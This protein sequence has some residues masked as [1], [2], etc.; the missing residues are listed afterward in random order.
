MDW[1]GSLAGMFDKMQ[2]EK[3]SKISLKLARKFV[4]TFFLSIFFLT[5]L[6]F[7]NS[8]SLFFYSWIEK[9]AAKYEART[10]RI[11][12]IH[13]TVYGNCRIVNMEEA[14]KNKD[15][16]CI[17]MGELIHNRKKYYHL[18]LT[19][20][21]NKP[22]KTVFFVD[23]TKKSMEDVKRDI[24]FPRLVIK[25]KDNCVP[26]VLWSIIEGLPFRDRIVYL[27]F[28]SYIRTFCETKTGL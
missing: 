22:Y 2:S 23:K 13:K 15:K 21:C 27:K 19:S 28:I 6:L 10:G 8:L 9:I 12:F 26:E 5:F 20:N 1:P 16:Y 18:W 7:E 3:K 17:V 4:L 25:L 24:Y 11:H 14:L